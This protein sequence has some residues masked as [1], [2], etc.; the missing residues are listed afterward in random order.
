MRREN[1]AA[2]IGVGHQDAVAAGERQIG[3]EGRTFGA[4]LFLDHLHQQHLAALDDFLDLVVPHRATAALLDLV[5]LHVVATQG[6]DDPGFHGGGHG[7]ARFGGGLLGRDDRL[8]LR[9]AVIA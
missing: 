9:H 5:I 2:A 6:F 4:A 7:G 1:S 8:A 3:R